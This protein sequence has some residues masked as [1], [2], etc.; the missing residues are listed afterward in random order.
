MQK[1]NTYKKGV[2]LWDEV[3]ISII[4]KKII[5]ES[6]LTTHLWKDIQLKHKKDEVALTQEKDQLIVTQEA[7]KN[8]VEEN[9]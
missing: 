5:Q 8:R 6:F 7:F 4:R 3:N 1:L 9:E 2:E